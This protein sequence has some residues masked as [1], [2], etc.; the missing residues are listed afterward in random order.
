MMALMSALTR[1]TL[2]GVVSTFCMAVG[3]VRSGAFSPTTW[4]ALR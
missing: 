4:R 3:A 2:M 1:W